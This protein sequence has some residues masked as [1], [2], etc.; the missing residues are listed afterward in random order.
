[1]MLKKYLALFVSV[2]IFI[3][4]V[5]MCVVNAAEEPAEDTLTVTLTPT[6]DSIIRKDQLDQ[7]FGASTSLNADIREGSRRYG[8]IRFDA[9]EIKSAADTASKIYFRYYASKQAYTNRVRVY[10]LYGNHKYF[11]ENTV[12]W[13]IASG[14]REGGV[15]LSDWLDNEFDV[16]KAADGEQINYVDVTDYIKSQDDYVYAFKTWAKE[17]NDNYAIIKS[18]EAKGFEPQLIF[19]TEI[20]YILEKAAAEIVSSISASSLTEDFY[21]PAQWNNSELLKDE[22]KVEWESSDE[23]VVRIEEKDGGYIAR[24]CERPE[25]E[26]KTAKLSMRIFYRGAEYE[27]ELDVRVIRK[28][29]IPVSGDT[30]VNGG[31]Y[32]DRV[33]GK[34]ESIFCADT[35]IDELD[36]TAYL[37]VDASANDEWRSAERRILRLYP[38]NRSGIQSGTVYVS[39]ANDFYGDIEKINGNNTLSCTFNNEIKAELVCENAMDIDVTDI[40]GD[41]GNVLFRLRTDSDGLEFFSSDSQKPPQIILL[42]EEQSKLYDEYSKLKNSF[43]EKR[44]EI[45]SDLSLPQESGGYVAE[46]TSDSGNIQ[47]DGSNIDVTRPE[48]TDTDKL[49]ELNLKLSGSTVSENFTIL[50]N[51][52]KKEADGVN[53]HRKLKDPMKLSDT[54]FFGQWNDAIGS[55]DTTPVLQYDT[56]EGLESVEYYAKRGNYSAA[57]EELLKYYRQRDVNLRYE[58]DAIYSRSLETK[59]AS[60]HIIGNQTPKATFKLEKDADW[61]E[62]EVPAGSSI[63]S[64]YMIFDRSKDGSTGVFYTKD[65]DYAPYM[66]VVTKSGVHILP[67]EMDTYFE[68]AAN[69]GNVNGLDNLMY[70]HEEGN[71]FNDNTKRAF[72][73]FDASE[74]EGEDG[75]KSVTVVLYGKKIGGKSDNM[76]LVLYQS[77][78]TSHISEKTACWNDITPG[79]FNFNDCIYDWKAPYGSEAEW[80]NS[81]ARLEDNVALVGEYLGMGNKDYAA[82]ALENII[83]IYTGQGAGYPRTLDSAWRTPALLTT[84]FGLID[85]EYMTPEV[86]CALIKYS[87]QMMEYFD[88]AST[89]SVVNQM[90]AA[91]LGFTRLVV[92]LPEIHDASYYERARS[93]LDTTIGTKITHADG[94]Y[95]E[96]TTGYM[97]RVIDEIL[98]AVELF[99]KIGYTDLDMYKDTAHRLS[100]FYANFFFPDGEM[101]PYGDGGRGTSFDKLYTLGEYFDDDMIRWQS[102]KTDVEEPEEYKSIIFPV[103][104]AVIMRDG[105]TENSLFAHMT[106]ETGHSHGHPDDLHLDI[107]AYGRPLLIDAGNGGG[108]NPLLP[109]TTVRTET[110]AHNTIEINEEPQGYDI[111]ENGMKLIANNSFDRAEGFAE[112]YS[113]FR[114]TRNVFFLHN[115]FWIVS[116][117][118]APQDKTEKNMYRQNWHPD[119]KA[120]MELDKT[121]GKVKTNFSGTANLQ[122]LQA[123]MDNTVLKTGR[124]YIKN[125]DL[126][127]RLEKYAFYE[128]EIKGDAVFNTLLFPTRSGENTEVDFNRI[129]VDGSIDNSASAANI[130]YGGKSGTYYISHEGKNAVREFGG[131]TTNADMIYAEDGADGKINYA[132][133][134]NGSEL[135]TDGRNIIHS[136][137]NIKDIAVRRIGDKLI[138]DTSDSLT[139]DVKIDID[140]KISS[141]TLNGIL[142][143]FETDG[144]AVILKADKII[145]PVEVKGSNMSYTF[146]SDYTASLALKKNGTVK[147]ITVAIPKGATV[148]GKLGWNGEMDFSVKESEAGLSVIFNADYGITFDKEITISVPYYMSEGGYFISG[149]SK[150]MFGSEV[151]GENK[152]GG[153]VLKSKLGAEFVLPKLF[154]ALTAAGGGGGGGGSV[155]KPTEKPV[156]SDTPEPSQTTNPTDTPVLKNSFSDI[157]GHWAEKYIGELHENGVLDGYEDNTYKPDRPL[158]RAEFV[159]IIIS[160]FGKVKKYSGEFTDVAQKDWFADYVSASVNEGYVSGYE[161]GSFRPNVKVTREEAAKILMLVYED[162][163]NKSLQGSGLSEYTDTSDISD[164]AYEYVKKAVECGLIQGTDDGRIEPKGNFTRAMAAAVI[165]R[166]MYN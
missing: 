23:T 128:K 65:T 158:T 97:H 76:Q 9:S 121:R 103:K 124:S 125:K 64:S 30:Y 37:S 108:Y 149:D 61:V 44:A 164:W 70:V 117:Y 131:F 160:A 99:E 165:Y 72:I 78:L 45:T 111:G 75:I 145:F 98:E 105:W 150:V 147:N 25:S 122:I 123:D 82:A 35:G 19:Y 52:L 14:I 163:D 54:E 50:L 49:C 156:P 92:Y 104:K 55:F 83:D 28:G 159:K 11:D 94:A 153:C 154:G 79:T 48:Y 38:N 93:R 24:I 46:W 26:D 68:G 40:C 63:T 10:P 85:S 21:L 77:T 62:I 140:E 107:Y 106:A 137:Q 81:M 60:E 161:D 112:T 20:N 71:P 155:S 116:D 146:D 42:D 69:S 151:T 56:T 43:F 89:P 18:K 142:R 114:H 27:S 57:K 84:I 8:L 132:A 157:K 120:N 115:G 110:Y 141:V 58:T 130:S 118:V 15:S 148:K 144:N 4:S 91:D 36:K 3:V 5:Q 109:A 59:L 51:V 95:K 138:I 39:A 129:E 102:H 1:M 119:N 134:V 139:S 12:T 17:G 143:S 16:P 126:A 32:A 66:R 7:N 2:V 22:C 87:Y 29:I 47:A 67:C 74:L 13:S 31:S 127:N 166:M 133:L 90:C 53:G 6:D 96:A 136:S 100:V 88:T 86:F 34:E 101:V 80:I 152:N 162:M 41:D 135:K 33:N 73:N 113:G